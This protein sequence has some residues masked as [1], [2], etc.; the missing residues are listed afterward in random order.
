MRER[1][2]AFWGRVLHALT[3]LRVAWADSRPR[4]SVEVSVSGSR[5][6]VAVVYE[7]EMG[8]DARR[9]WDAAQ[10]L[11]GLAGVRGEFLDNGQLRGVWPQER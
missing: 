9:F 3:A 7:G 1:L 4:P 2:R 8:A 6:R 10:A 5:F 11:K